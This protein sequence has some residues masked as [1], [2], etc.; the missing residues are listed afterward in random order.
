MLFKT[1]PFTAVCQSCCRLQHEAE[2][3]EVKRQQLAEEARLAAE[4]ARIQQEKETKDAQDQVKNLINARPRAAPPAAAPS[5]AA[6][7]SAVPLRFSP[8]RLPASWCNLAFLASA[9]EHICLSSNGW[10]CR[11]AMAQTTDRM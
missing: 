6:P 8:A 11:R 4:A 3:A 1:A 5:G 7:S 2:L 10:Q 9:Y